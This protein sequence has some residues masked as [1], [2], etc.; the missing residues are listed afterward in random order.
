MESVT[1]TIQTKGAKKGKFNQRTCEAVFIRQSHT[2]D[3]QIFILEPTRNDLRNSHI[4]LDSDSYLS[5]CVGN[6]IYQ[7]LHIEFPK[8]PSHPIVYTSFS[9][10]HIPEN[11]YSISFD[12]VHVRNRKESY[13]Y[14]SSPRLCPGIRYTDLV[15]HLYDETDYSVAEI[16]DPTSDI[17]SRRRLPV[18]FKKLNPLSFQKQFPNDIENY[19]SDPSSTIVGIFETFAYFDRCRSIIQKGFRF[20]DGSAE[21]EIIGVSYLKFPRFPILAISRVSEHSLVA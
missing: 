15:K 11:P 12:Y 14:Q 1:V 2:P 17:K 8:R 19:L 9:G 6:W 3:V 4:I 18:H 7:S 20:F 5:I 13:R 10:Y 21:Y 16:Y